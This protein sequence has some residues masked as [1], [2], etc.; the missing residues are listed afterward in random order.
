MQDSHHKLR[1]IEWVDLL[2]GFAMLAILLFHTEVYAIDTAIINY[3]IYVENALALF[4]FLSGYLFNS[5]LST[6]NLRYKLYR[7]FRTLIIPYFLFTLLITLAKHLLLHQYFNIEAILFG[8]ASWFVAA[9]IVSEIIFALILYIIRSIGN[10]IHIFKGIIGEGIVFLF[11]LFISIYGNTIIA[12]DIWCINEAML[13]LPIM[14]AGY[15]Y[16]KHEHIF[17][18]YLG[19]GFVILLSFVVLVAIKIFERIESIDLIFQP[20]DIN[21]YLV[22]FID[23]LTSLIVLIAL[24]K[25]FNNID[26]I[27]LTGRY[28]LVIY[29]FSGAIPLAVNTLFRT[30]YPQ[31]TDFYILL[32]LAF[33]TIWIITLAIA[34]VIY[35]YIPFVIGREFHRPEQCCPTRRAKL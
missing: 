3:S 10:N 19:K 8:N 2:R 17:N 7:I 25:Y 30:I 27:N 29:F 22:F 33:I 31:Y 16:H 26:S 5:Q 21:N 23:I 34:H 18:Q 11:F 15:G 13:A 28:S 1:R 35:K 6:F 14:M 9:L 12:S 4:F 24:A 32:F 20:V